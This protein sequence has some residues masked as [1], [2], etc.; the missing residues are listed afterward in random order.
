MMKAELTA[1]QDSRIDLKGTVSGPLADQLN[2]R[3]TVASTK[4]DGFLFHETTGQDF[5]DKD[6]TA[7]RGSLQWI[8]SNSLEINVAADY[9]SSSINGSAITNG[10]TI[11][12]DPTQ[13]PP[14]GNFTYTHNVILGMFTGCDGTPAN[15]AGSLDNPNCIND[16][17]RDRITGEGPAFADID[18]YGINVTIDWNLNERLALK[19]ITSH[20]S[21]DAH[22]NRDKDHTPHLIVSEIED[23]VDQAQISTE[24]QLLGNSFDDR[25]TWIVGLFYFQEDGITDNPVRFQPLSLQ[26]GGIFDHDS[27]AVFAQGTYDINDRTHLTAGIRFTRDN[28][29]FLPVQFITEN[30]T[31]NPDFAPGTPTLPEVNSPLETNDSSPHVSLSYDFN[32]GLM[33]YLSYSEGFKGGGH[34]QRVFPPIIPAQGGCDPSTPVECI[35]TFKPEFV[36]SYEWGLK[37]VGL[38]GRIRVNFATFYSDY[39]DLQITVLT[40]LAD[41][42]R[43]TL[44]TA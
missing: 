12:L 25:L 6:Q 44:T 1:G 23:R 39:S 16:Q 36:T 29:N 7:A 15:P 10:G 26:S 32:D 19:S 21:V 37:Y 38:D 8:P 18:T 2:G 28:K 34:H 14:T 31:P 35:P 4:Q 40:S 41:Q 3:L 24:L 42:C 11:F 9:T 20:R 17:W 13:I 30:R 5:G 22:V 27:T 33:T 43:T